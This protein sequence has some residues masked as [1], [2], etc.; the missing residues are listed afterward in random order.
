MSE[1]DIFREVDE[2]LRR[3]EFAK[4]WDRYGVFVLLCAALIVI[5]VGAYQ[6]FQ[7]RQNS[8][9]SEN[10]KAFYQ[11]AQ[12]VKDG[13]DSEALAAY[14]TL[15]AQAPE[16]YRVLA[17]L[18][19]AALK[20][21]EGKKAEAVAL[22]DQ[23]GKSAQDAVLKN[24]ATLQAAALRSD[25]ADLKEMTDRLQGLNTANNPWRHSA[26]ELLGLVA[27]RSGNVAESEKFFGQ[28]RLDTQTPDEMRKRAENMLS[29]LVKV[30]AKDA[31]TGKDA[32]DKNTA[33]Q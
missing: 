22:Y 29:L 13:K 5:T 18:E 4:L 14:G 7:W 11:A 31:S 25:E 8:I 1:H 28:I 24:Y 2:D 20:V 9:S 16:G 15:A 33:T 21:K 3:E 12:L 23:V 10:G 32:A 6:F 30:P 17:N 26:R 27:F 19:I